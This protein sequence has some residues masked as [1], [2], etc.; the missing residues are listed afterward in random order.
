M[1]TLEIKDWI[2]ICSV[3][4]VIFGWFVNGYLNRKNEIAKNKLEHR[5]PTLK[6]FLKVV[7]FI[8]KN[9]SPFTEKGFI[10]DI[11]NVRMDFFLY[12]KDDE[13]KLYEK[14]IKSCE[15]QNLE[16]ANKALFELKYLVRERIR[17]ELNI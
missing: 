10:E 2:T 4:A 11:E 9:E 16:G 7:V 6:S 3:L 12:G 17:K 8:D 13:I 5:L 1:E 15:S 14:F